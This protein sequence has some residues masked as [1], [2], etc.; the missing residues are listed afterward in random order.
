VKTRKQ[1]EDFKKDWAILNRDERL[2]KGA[3]HIIGACKELFTHMSNACRLINRRTTRI[4]VVIN[5]LKDTKQEKWHEKYHKIARNFFN[6]DYERSTTETREALSQIKKES[7]RN[8]DLE[9]DFYLIGIDA[10]IKNGNPD[11]DMI[12]D[13]ENLATNDP[14]IMLRSL[15]IDI[16]E[17]EISRL[18][19]INHI[20]AMK[21]IEI[22][23]KI[24]EKFRDNKDV[25]MY[26][27]N[28]EYL[29]H[30]YERHIDLCKKKKVNPDIEEK[31]IER[32]RTEGFWRL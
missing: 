26:K 5:N 28:K 1:L 20:D 30:C 6:G 4:G 9:I 31:K 25:Y 10:G 21:N 7:V 27:E 16:Q 24:H 11:R 32:D 19:D 22:E 13:G 2:W 18:N 14:A 23:A 3:E 15:M 12:T 17:F 29:E 8:L